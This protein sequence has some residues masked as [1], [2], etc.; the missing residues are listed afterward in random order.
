[1]SV[2]KPKAEEISRKLVNKANEARLALAEFCALQ[3]ELAKLAERSSTPT[4]VAAHHQVMVRSTELLRLNAMSEAV[5]EVQ[6]GLLQHLTGLSSDA[7]RSPG[8]GVL[9]LSISS[10]SYEPVKKVS[11]KLVEG[12][13][14]LFNAMKMMVENGCMDGL[15]R[16]V[17]AS[18][19]ASP[20]GTPNALGRAL[21]EAG[22][23]TV[24][25]EPAWSVKKA[26]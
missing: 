22:L 26:K 14:V 11:A 19:V 25:A 10:Y 13:T 5:K 18:A 12:P 2:L 16:R 6:E 17:K 9:D 4:E 7:F 20:D 15:E 1:M 3:A 8:L 24:S 23:A 21:I